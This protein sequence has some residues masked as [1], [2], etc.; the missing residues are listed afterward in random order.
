MKALVAGLLAT[1]IADI[2]A[3][4][5]S[6]WLATARFD[7]RPHDIAA[8]EAAGLLVTREGSLGFSHQTV[9]DYVLSR[10][11]ARVNGSLSNYVLERQVSLFLRPKLWAVLTY[12]RVV[13]TNAYHAEFEAIWSA[14][15]LRRHLRLL[16][17]EFLGQQTQPTDREALLMERALGLPNDRWPAFRGLSGSPGWFKRF[18]RTFV[19]ECMS[20]SDEA[21]AHMVE[22]LSRAWGFGSRRRNATRARTLGAPPPTR[23]KKLD[24]SPE[25]P[26]RWT[27]DSLALACTIVKRTEI[28]PIV[29][30]HSS[31]NNRRRAAR[32][33]VTSGSRAAG[34]RTCRRAS[35]WGRVGN[36]SSARVRKC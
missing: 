8:L 18:A 9:F 31:C 4:E 34:S 21:A 7:D 20:D 36:R 32:S 12:L 27:D 25:M 30:D 26:R 19:A 15:D 13:N 6:L 2:M 24:G 16:L 28:A 33:C 14:P 17:I 1:R 23:R 35:E 11:F 5:E 29:I 3:E 10:S 22:V